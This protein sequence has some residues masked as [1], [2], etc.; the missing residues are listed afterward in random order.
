MAGRR[1]G[2]LDLREML[3]RFRLG[4]GNR[5][6]ARDLGLSRNS[7]AKYRTWAELEG[8]LGGAELPPPEVIEERLGTLMLKQPGP[9][10]PLEVHR[11]TIV[12]LRSKGVEVR[13]LLGRLRED[14]G[15][16]GSYSALLRYVGRL[17]P[18]RPEVFLRI[19]TAPGEEAQVDFGYAG[20]IPDPNGRPRKAWVFIM[21]LSFSRHQYAEVVFDQKVETWV[22]LHVRAFEFLGGV[23]KRIVIDNLK[24]AIVRAVIHDPQAQRSYREL[25]EHYGF[26][27]SPCRPRM[28]RHKGK[29]ESGVRYVKRNALAGRT[30]RSLREV[31]EHLRRWIHDV[32]GVRD[33]GTTHERPLVR[34]ESEREA[35]GALPESR[36]EIVVWKM[37]KLHPDCHLVYDYSFYSA[38]YRYVGEELWVRVTPERLV[39][40]REHER[41]ASHPRAKRRGQWSTHPDHY[42][43]EKLQGLLPAPVEVQARARTIG[44]HTG[45][46]VERLLGER[47]LDRLRGAQ[48]VLHLARRYGAK[49]LEAA[50]RRALAF[51]EVR[52]TTVKT[53]LKE[54]LDLERLS[55]DEEALPQP[56]TAI[57]ARP[58]ADLIPIHN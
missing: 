40:Y 20:I 14:H 48:G 58:I 46:L 34:F 37:A 23:A 35:L 12:D 33:H 21:T 26:L 24:A 28:A 19:E 31:N 56:K 45:E 55:S 18:Q 30:F 27:I 43:A 25:A 9:V 32:A 51:G 36:Y 10:S 29:V 49:R 57:F 6:V 54:G 2:V 1:I 8:F 16:Q 13:A 22:A 15:Y 41:V 17:E 4:E 52:Y 38:P 39:V 42:P 7:V 5:G 3:R 53:I 11:D 50:C 47:P 44:R